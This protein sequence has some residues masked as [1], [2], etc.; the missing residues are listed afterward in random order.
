MALRGRAKNQ[1][2]AQEELFDKR[3]KCEVMN[4]SN[5]S[6][7]QECIPVVLVV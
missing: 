4:D 2:V 1:I 7:P 3:T 5:N 6:W